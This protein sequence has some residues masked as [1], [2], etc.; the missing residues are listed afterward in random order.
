MYSINDLARIVFAYI[1]RTADA[2]RNL[3]TYLAP[4]LRPEF[5]DKNEG[6]IN[7]DALL[8][9]LSAPSDAALE[10]IVDV[11][12]DKKQGPELRALLEA[13]AEKKYGEKASE[14]ISSREVPEDDEKKLMDKLVKDFVPLARKHIFE[15]L[16]REKL[17]WIKKHEK[18]VPTEEEKIPENVP[19]EE[20]ATPGMDLQ[21]HEI[22]Q[23]AK[24]ERNWEKGLLDDIFNHLDK[25]FPD[26]KKRTFMKYLL[27]E[28]FLSSHPKKIEEI[29]ESQKASVGTVHKYLT[30]LKNTLAEFLRTKGL[31]S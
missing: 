4:Y 3:I 8:K 19:W 20:H 22:E 30:L 14:W 23:E 13:H 25:I 15:Y 17:Q 16:Y 7:F 18:E 31:G 5:L 28:M 1:I 6:G 24:E 11:F 12:I 10:D 29:A 2:K 26:V 27:N 21:E 9:G